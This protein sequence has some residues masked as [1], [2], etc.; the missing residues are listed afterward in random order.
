MSRNYEQHPEMFPSPA[1]AVADYD[2]DA[3]G[4]KADA[5]AE[6]EAA[7][8]AVADYCNSAIELGAPCDSVQA[9]GPSEQL[10]AKSHCQLCGGTGRPTKKTLVAGIDALNS[11]IDQLASTAGDICT[12]AKNVS[13]PRLVAHGECHPAGDGKVLDGLQT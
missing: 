6:L 8:E 7:K 3:D 9:Y 13:R 2:P 4:W 12:P 10:L 11:K 1:V 5:R